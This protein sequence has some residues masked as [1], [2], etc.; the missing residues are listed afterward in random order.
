M[1]LFYPSLLVARLQERGEPLWANATESAVDWGPALASAQRRA[2]IH[3]RQ[4]LE[5]LCC[6]A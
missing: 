2:N 4:M 3:D 1:R 5:L 6:K